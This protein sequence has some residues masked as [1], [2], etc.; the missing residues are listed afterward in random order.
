MISPCAEHPEEAGWMSLIPHRQEQGWQRLPGAKGQAA[1]FPIYAKGAGAQVPATGCSA[2]GAGGDTQCLSTP[3]P[4]EH[5][6]V[7]KT[8]RVKGRR[9][10]WAFPNRSLAHDVS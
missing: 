2:F 5:V 9:W 1:G 4:G 7:Q 8:W 10:P 6:L 3:T